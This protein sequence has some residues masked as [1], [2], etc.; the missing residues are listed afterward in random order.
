MTTIAKADKNR[1][2][3]RGVRDGCTYLVKK[4]PGGWWIEA[5]SEAK[6]KRQR[7]IHTATRDLVEHLD[8]LAAEGFSFGPKLNP[9]IPPCRF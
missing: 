9:E 4:E 3:V 7:E 8:A 2:T 5:V 6:P 1:I